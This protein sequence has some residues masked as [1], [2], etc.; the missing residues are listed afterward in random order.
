[1]K[2][3]IVASIFLA[4]CATIQEENIEYANSCAEKGSKEKIIACH[5]EAI[6][7]KIRAKWWVSTDGLTESDIPVIF[8][9]KSKIKV[10]QEGKVLSAILLSSSNSR[11]LDKSVLKGI[12]RS[13]P[14]PVPKE[15]LFSV[16]KFSEIRYIFV[17]STGDVEPLF[18]NE[19][20]TTTRVSDRYRF[21]RR[22]TP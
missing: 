1:M 20:W 15:P 3:L 18:S 6:F 22:E 10:D 12:S 7:Y 16:G 14:L 21:A 4:G 17:H 2:S 5:Q 13:S 8:N 19:N 11:N 9:I